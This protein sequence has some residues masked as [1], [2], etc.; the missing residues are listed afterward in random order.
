MAGNYAKDKENGLWNLVENGQLK[1][2][3]FQFWKDE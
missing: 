2:R 1:D 3:I